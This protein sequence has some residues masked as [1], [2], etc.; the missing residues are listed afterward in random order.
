MSQLSRQ[1]ILQHVGSFVML[2]LMFVLC[3][4]QRVGRRIPN[5]GFLL[6]CGIANIVALFVPPEKGMSP[7]IGVSFSCKGFISLGIFLSE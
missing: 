2:S 4:F 6:L 3:L 5:A 1:I 7:E